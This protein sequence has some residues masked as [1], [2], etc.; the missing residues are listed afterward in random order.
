MQ[1]TDSKDITSMKNNFVNL[2]DKSFCVVENFLSTNDLEIIRQD[3]E[4]IKTSDFLNPSF[5]ILPVGKKIS[6]SS[7]LSKIDLLATDIQTS[8]GI[9]TNFT[10]T[11]IYF[12]IEHGVNFGYHQ[13][14][15]SWFLYGDHTNYLNIW[16]PIIKPDTTLTNVVVLDLDKLIQDHSELAF[17]KNYGATS[18]ES[19]ATSYIFD[20]NT[21]AKIELAFDL[22][23]YAECPLMKEGDALIMRGYCIHK[24]QDTLTNR[25]AISARRQL[26]TSTVHK[27]H[28]DITSP[29]KKQI[30]EKNPVMYKKIME[31]FNNQDTCT[32]GDLLSALKS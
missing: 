20:D 25:V 9:A 22:D 19:G 3:F 18:F 16:V 11:P 29:N 24:T 6:I 12:S 10:S 23:E 28:F 30:I 27:S 15:E 26:S 13:D 5:N 7:T 31:K 17:L 8:V 21:G 2:L 14:H 4:L 1:R 32:I